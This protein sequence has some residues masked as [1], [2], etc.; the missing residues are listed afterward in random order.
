[1]NLI[2]VQR[3]RLAFGA[4]FALLYIGCVLVMLTVGR[5][6]TVFLFNSLMHGIDVAPIIKMGIPLLDMA[7][8]VI[9]MFILGWLIG[10]TIASIYNF[11]FRKNREKR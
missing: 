5:E 2:N 9:E 6:G 1:M 10:A 8:G 7:M 3:F 4:T 11:S